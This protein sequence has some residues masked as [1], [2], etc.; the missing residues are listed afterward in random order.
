MTDE[1]HKT[2]FSY[3]KNM[4]NELFRTLPVPF[5]LFRLTSLKREKCMNACLIH[6]HNS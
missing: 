6:L 5:A 1:N 2:L 4:R 3:L